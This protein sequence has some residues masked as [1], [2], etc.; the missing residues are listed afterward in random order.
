MQ[1]CYFPEFYLHIANHN[2]V[3]SYKTEEK[4]ENILI[5]KDQIFPE[6]LLYLF[7]VFFFFLTAKSLENV[8]FLF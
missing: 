5:E 4:I 2:A 7:F 6:W 8:L 1:S 3:Q